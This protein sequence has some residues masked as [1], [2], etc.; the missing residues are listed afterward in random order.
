MFDIEL[1][2]FNAPQ[3]LS[4]SSALPC[5]QIVS[6]RFPDCLVIDRVVSLNEAVSERDHFKQKLFPFEL[7]R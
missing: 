1:V 3:R 5:R 6:N 7:H 2:Y 4:I